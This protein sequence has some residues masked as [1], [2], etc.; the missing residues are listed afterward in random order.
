[1]R[2]E[3]Q[4]FEAKTDALIVDREQAEHHHKVY[5]EGEFEDRRAEFGGGPSA[6]EDDDAEAE[7]DE[8]LHTKVTTDKN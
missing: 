7:G 2:A 3:Q 5:A 1:M 8:T 4:M 6:T